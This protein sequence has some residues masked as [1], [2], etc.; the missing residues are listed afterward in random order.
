MQNEK[1]E[2]VEYS[3]CHLLNGKIIGSRTRF[4]AE[5]NATG[6]GGRHRITRDA[7]TV[8]V[9]ELHGS[10]RVWEIPRSECV[11]ERIALPGPGV[12]KTEGK[13]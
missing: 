8:F 13:R 4:L 1:A 10:H 3:A 7:E 5:E 11:L 9:E 2:K 6:G 12:S